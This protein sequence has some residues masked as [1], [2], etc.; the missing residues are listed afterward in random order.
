[1]IEALTAY[2]S[3]H[4]TT[5]AQLLESW[6]SH[7]DLRIRREFPG[8]AVRDPVVLAVESFLVHNGINIHGE[9]VC[10]PASAAELA[11]QGAQFA[12]SP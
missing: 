1:M 6:E 5:P 12:P 7:A 8:V 4:G 3:R 9:I 2:C 10:V 11:D